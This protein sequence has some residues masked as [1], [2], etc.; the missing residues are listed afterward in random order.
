MGIVTVDLD[1]P[2]VFQV[3]RSW[4]TLESFGGTVRGRVSSSGEGVHLRAD[5]CRTRGIAERE[6]RI[7]G[8]DAKRIDLDIERDYRPSQVLFDSKGGKKAGSWVDDMESLLTEY[9]QSTGYRY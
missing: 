5:G 1:R 4:H 7:A 6:R 9:Q 8:D 3:V 2:T